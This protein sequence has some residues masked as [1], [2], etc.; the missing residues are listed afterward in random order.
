MARMG[1]LTA[2]VAL[3]GLLGAALA[4]DTYSNPILDTGA[5]PWMVKHDDGYYYLTYTTATNITLS[6]SRSLVNWENAD[7]KLVFQ[8]PEGK[9]YS[10]DL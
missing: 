9:D 3:T 4:Q 6:R 8:P 1:L 5:D 7:T 10:T 2:A